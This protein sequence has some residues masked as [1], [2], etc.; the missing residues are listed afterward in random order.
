MSDIVVGQELLLG[1]LMNVLDDDEAVKVEHEL[2]KQPKLRNELAKLQKNLSPLDILLDSVEPPPELAKRTCDNIWITQNNNYNNNPNNQNL[3]I[4]PNVESCNSTNNNN[5]SEKNNLLETIFQQPKINSD[6]SD[7]NNHSLDTAIEKNLVAESTDNIHNTDYTNNTANNTVNTVNTNNTQ[8]S[9]ENEPVQK[10]ITQIEKDK[11]K[12]EVCDTITKDNNCNDNIIVDSARVI[13]RRS[14]QIVSEERLSVRSRILR[15][16]VIS[17][18]IGI[19]LALVIYPFTNYFMGQV[20][21]LA[22]RQKVEQLD[23]SVD[24]YSQLSE[25]VSQTSP[26]EINLT[27]YG[28]Q[29]LIPASEYISIPNDQQFSITKIFDKDDSY[30]STDNLLFID[31]VNQPVLNQKNNEISNEITDTFFLAQ[32]PDSNYSEVIDEH[33]I[34]KPIFNIVGDQDSIFN[35]SQPILVLEGS[36]IKPAVGQSIL[37]QNGR[38]FFRILPQSNNQ[39]IND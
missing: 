1:Y 4:F 20:V 34:N 35:L 2:T 8:N 5:N 22:V 24:V 3:R 25:P 6:L 37:I 15:Q 7:K 10:R 30:S 23:K 9:V 13:R 12:Q 33:N 39:K 32:S 11:S 26:E 17:A 27:R 28:W 29:E 38:I 19:L 21:Q 16:I 18:I 14:K 31:S 36:Q